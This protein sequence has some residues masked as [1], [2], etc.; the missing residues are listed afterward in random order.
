MSPRSTTPRKK[1]FEKTPEKAGK[2]K[3][4]RP[5]SDINNKSMDAAY[6]VTFNEGTNANAFK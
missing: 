6:E 2:L 4:N 5:T 3:M 1:I